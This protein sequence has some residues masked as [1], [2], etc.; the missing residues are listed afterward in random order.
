[1]TPTNW[2]LHFRMIDSSVFTDSTRGAVAAGSAEKADI[3]PS[4]P[5]SRYSLRPRNV[6]RAKCTR[7]L[8]T[9]R[10]TCN[11]GFD[12]Y[13]AARK[14]VCSS[15]WPSP[16]L[17]SYLCGM[18]RFVLESIRLLLRSARM[19]QCRQWLQESNWR[20]AG[21]PRLVAATYKIPSSNSFVLGSLSVEDDLGLKLT[22]HVKTWM[23]CSRSAHLSRVFA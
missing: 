16:N 13:L 22:C 1:M 8:S 3:A 21:A 2:S 10:E 6:L 11:V 20:S 9:R 7:Q 18:R 14:F 12:L 19:P 17:N 23:Q 15:G 4:E 5:G